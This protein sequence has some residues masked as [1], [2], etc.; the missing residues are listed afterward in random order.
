MVPNGSPCAI[1]RFHNQEFKAKHKFV[2]TF[3]FSWVC[4]WSFAYFDQA[5]HNGLENIMMD[6]DSYI[7]II[8][9]EKCGH[10]DLSV[11]HFK[12]II[13]TQGNWKKS[14]PWGAVLELPA[15]KHCQYPDHLPNIGLNGLNWQCCLAGSFKMAPGFWFVQL[16]W[17]PNLHFSW[18]LLLPKHHKQLIII[19][20][21]VVWVGCLCIF[22]SYIASNFVFYSY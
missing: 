18:N 10:P 8:M 7:W 9:F 1:C 21:L 22:M 12:W 5:G 3:R 14:K 4:M 16:P 6:Q 13:G 15:I 19:H 11:F 17:M 20:S 2:H